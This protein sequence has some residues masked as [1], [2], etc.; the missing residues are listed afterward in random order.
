[1]LHELFPASLRARDP[2]IIKYF[3]K[4][5]SNVTWEE[6]VTTKFWLWIDTRLS[7]YNIFHRRGM[8][9]EKS[10]IS[11]EVEKT[12]ESSDGDLTY[13]VFSLEDTVALLAVTNHSGIL[14]T[15]N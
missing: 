9:A 12:A 6:I 13:H 3:C 2:E 7:T 5:H 8:A 1:M 14:T 4:E 15:E 11:I 10:G